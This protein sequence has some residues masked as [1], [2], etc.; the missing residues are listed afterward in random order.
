M[1]VS[2]SRLTRAATHDAG[3]VEWWE[4]YYYREPEADIEMGIL[5]MTSS[6][7]ANSQGNTKTTADEVDCLLQ[8]DAD[9]ITVRALSVLVCCW[10]VM[11]GLCLG[12]DGVCLMRRVHCVYGISAQKDTDVEMG[13]HLPRPDIDFRVQRGR[14]GKKS[15]DLTGGG[16]PAFCLGTQ[17]VPPCRGSW[18]GCLSP[19]STGVTLPSSSL[20]LFFS[21]SPLLPKN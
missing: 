8:V 9:K 6:S 13:P 10:S 14:C 16:S 12:S 2:T 1:A 19:Q 4:D 17:A 15:R 11:F 3:V 7:S 5:P 21:P 20:L 18:M